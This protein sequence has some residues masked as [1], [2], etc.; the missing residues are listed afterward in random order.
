LTL[1]SLALR[2]QSLKQLNAAVQSSRWL[3]PLAT[4]AA[5]V[6]T[7][8]TNAFGSSGAMGGIRT[9]AISGAFHNSHTS[10]STAPQR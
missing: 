9:G 3:V 1:D 8:I 2:M 10:H 7:V 6:F 4:A 5:F